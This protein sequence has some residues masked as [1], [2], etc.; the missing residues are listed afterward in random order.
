MYKSA[1]I[2]TLSLVCLVASGRAANAPVI[3]NHSLTAN[4]GDVLYFQAA[5]IGADPLIQYSYN[6]PSWINLPVLETSAANGV[7]M[8]KIPTTELRLPDLFQVRVSA[9]GVT[10]SA[11]VSIN[12]ATATSFDTDQAAA[13][14]PFRIWGR[15][16]YLGH[17]P[18][19]RF[20]D[21]AS[22]AQSFATV[23]IAASSSKCLTATAPVGIV[24]GDAYQVYVSNGLVGD[25]T[26]PVE[27][28]TEETLLGRSAGADYWSLGLPWANDL[29]FYGNVYNIQ[30]DPRLNRHAN[31]QG[32][33]GDI[34]AI[35]NA[36]NVAT[37]AG[38]GVVLLPAGIYNLDFTNDCGLS[39]YPRVVVQGAGKTLTTVNY[40]FGPVP[41]NGG[42]AAC[43][44]A[45]SGMADLTM[46]N[47]NESGGWPQSGFSNGSQKVF[48]QRIGWHIGTSQWISFNNMKYVTI[49][50]S[51]IDQGLDA[52]FNYNG[53]LDL[54]GSSQVR[55]IGNTLQYAVGG[56][57]LNNTTDISF[58]NNTVSRDAS[59]VVTGQCC[60]HNI[61]ANFAKD[62]VVLGNNFNV[63]NGVLPTGDT[64]DGEVLNTEAGGPTRFD[65]FRGTVSSSAATT[66]TD[67][68]QNFGQS[69][70]FN[71]ALQVGA[72]VAIVSGT[73]SGQWRTVTAISSDEQTLTIDSAWAVLP[74]AGAHYATFD[75]SANNWIVA[76]NQMTGNNKGIEFF[77]ASTH[78]ILVDSNILTD[79]SGIMLAPDERLPGLFNVISD[80]EVLNNTISDLAGLRPAYITV[81]PRED[82]E[83]TSFGTSIT[84]F[85]ARGNQ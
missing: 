4:A 50:N 80:F 16:L 47:V 46:N 21:Q 22:G 43:F 84:G 63:I 31:G 23:N 77:Q 42:Y 32:N 73:G 2:A 1:I 12:V 62:F 27:T 34:S 65:E 57:L 53:M 85:E 82:G 17:T 11:P 67:G 64:N 37:A 5:G 74:E 79:S 13:G 56:I 20:V 10:W 14:S 69:A 44:A 60:T 78:N 3:L 49:Q 26:T 68:G 55:V 9:D 41:S 24:A 8:A 76:N 54:S 30:T 81:V 45:Q 15:N 33:V 61:E 28:L 75:W 35:Q 6:S 51:A 83:T 19:I 40:G 52:G 70:N 36:I 71:S 29:N 66:I 39:L 7:I 38:G 18:T 48:L 25:G 59:Q 58:E 72:I